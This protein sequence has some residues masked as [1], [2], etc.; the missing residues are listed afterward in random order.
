MGGHPR[1]GGVDRVALDGAGGV[2]AV[3]PQDVAAHARQQLHAVPTQLA[4]IAAGSPASTPASVARAVA[5]RYSRPDDTH[6]TPSAAATRRATLDLPDA[7]GPSSVTTSGAGEVHDALT[8]TPHVRRSSKYPGYVFATQA[9]SRMLTPG[10]R[11]AHQGER[12]R[13]AV[14]AVGV[15]LDRWR[16]RVERH[17]RSASSRSSTSAPRRRSSMA[18]ARSRSVS[19]IR[20]LPTRTISTGA[21]AT[22][23]STA[24]V[25]AW[26]GQVVEVER[27]AAQAA[28]GGSP[29]RRRPRT[30]PPRSP[31]A[32]HVEQRLV[33]LARGRADVAT[34]TR[35]PAMAA[36][37]QAYPAAMASPSTA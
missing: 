17:T 14:V 3:D 35:P 4:R 31:S 5:A 30:T 2:G 18:S 9:G 19:L 33:A 25:C 6:G 36:R 34:R 7:A 10:Q 13:H 24:S 29:Q 27:A 21:S 1:H 26:S 20:R 37:P 16:R 8:P 12:H 15:D 32:Q 11:A 22:S 23:A 28:A